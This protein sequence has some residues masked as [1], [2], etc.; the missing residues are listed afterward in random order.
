MK[1]RSSQLCRL[2]RSPLP[3][4]SVVA[5]VAAGGCLSDS[6]EGAEGEA[7]AI[8]SV[9]A[10]AST[11]TYDLDDGT[12]TVSR[13]YDTGD[14]ESLSAWQ[15]VLC[16]A[17]AGTERLLVKLQ[18]FR[19]RSGNAD[20][21]VARMRA[22]CRNYAANDPLPYNVDF[23]TSDET[24]LVFTSNY[25]SDSGASE[26]TIGGN[27][28]KVPVGIRVK[29]NDAD[30]YLKDFQMLYR[31]AG[32]TGL[33]SALQSASYAMDLTGTEHTLECPED[34]GLTGVEVRYSTNKGKVRAIRAKC[35]LLVHR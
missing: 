24:D 13:T 20:N 35:S 17:Q 32:N 22:T 9:I 28:D 6:D 12:P 11:V 18:G 7:P 5:A 30:N 8:E 15:G 27:G 19:E 25:R 10:S 33:G 3:A 31:V 4:L 34:Y 29:F 26:V 1:Q 16:S 14:T 23:P 21:F 2:A